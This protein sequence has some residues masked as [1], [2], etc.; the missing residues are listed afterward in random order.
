MANS[1]DGA[2]ILIFPIW[3]NLPNY[4]IPYHEGTDSNVVHISLRLYCKM[5]LVS[6]KYFHEHFKLCSILDTVKVYKVILRKCLWEA[7]PFTRW[8]RTQHRERNISES[9]T[10]QQ[11]FGG[12]CF[13]AD[14]HFLDKSGFWVRKD[15]ALIPA[16]STAWAIEVDSQVSIISFHWHTYILLKERES[17]KKK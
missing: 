12:G 6:I 9:A 5:Y 4:P 15:V 14:S 2:I 1:L 17:I 11:G 13:P 7:L 10:S 8:G 3:H 16:Q